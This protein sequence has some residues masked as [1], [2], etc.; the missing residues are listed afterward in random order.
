MFV[1][2]V[3]G[4][5]A[6]GRY[7]VAGQENLDVL[8]EIRIGPR[9]GLC[10]IDLTWDTVGGVEEYGLSIGARIVVCFVKWRHWLLPTVS[11]TCAGATL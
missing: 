1:P 4:A 6:R 9:A 3:V 2:A 11:G 5:G 8:V 10:S 7:R